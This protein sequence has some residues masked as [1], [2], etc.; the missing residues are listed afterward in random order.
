MKLFFFNIPNL[1][2]FT[3]TVGKIFYTTDIS[4]KVEKDCAKFKVMILLWLIDWLQVLMLS[5]YN[6]MFKIED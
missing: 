5:C 3:V 4:K 1:H 6:I 2:F